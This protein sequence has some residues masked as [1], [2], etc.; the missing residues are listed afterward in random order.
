MKSGYPYSLST[1]SYLENPLKK[2][3]TEV[4]IPNSNTSCAC[5]RVM[6]LAC[7]PGWEEC[8]GFERN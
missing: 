5:K 1:I 2:I 3:E 6:R 7:L 4:C 8:E